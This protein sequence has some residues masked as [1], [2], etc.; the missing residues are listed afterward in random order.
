[1]CGRIRA[2]DGAASLN[3][4]SRPG[5]ERAGAQGAAIERAF[6]LVAK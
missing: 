3:A 1:M 5:V 4:G 6:G 2:S